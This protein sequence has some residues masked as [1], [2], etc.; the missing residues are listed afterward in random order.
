[1]AP[2]LTDSDIRPRAFEKSKVKYA[3]QVLS[4]TVSAALDTYVTLKTLPPQAKKNAETNRNVGS[5]I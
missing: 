3:S 5:T 1:M 2:K 4:A